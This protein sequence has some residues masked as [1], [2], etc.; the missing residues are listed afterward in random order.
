V[1]QMV[2]S[3]LQNEVWR[4][5]MCDE[6]SA[7]ERNGTWELV[8]LPAGQFFLSLFDLV[9]NRAFRAVRLSDVVALVVKALAYITEQESRCYGYTLDGQRRSRDAVVVYEMFNGGVEMI[10]LYIR[11]STDESRCYRHTLDV[12]RMSR[13]AIVIHEMFN[14]GVEMLS[15]RDAIVV[16]E[17][18]N[19]LVE[20]LSP[21][22]TCST[23]ESRCYH[24]TLEVQRMSRDAIVVHDMF[25]G[26]IEMLSL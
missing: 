3:A 11:C 16:H 15:S 20:M 24:Y 21:Y 13:D 12:Q 19:G 4:K 18:F 10:S 9:V 7:I 5:A 2:E 17:M 8:D 14:G 25:N 1:K 6:I 26:G 23:E 22:M